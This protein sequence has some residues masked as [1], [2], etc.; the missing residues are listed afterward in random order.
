MIKRTIF[1]SLLLLVSF[2]T[3]AQT[4]Q[5]IRFEVP[6]R[7]GTSPFNYVACGEDGVCLFY[8]TIEETGKDSISWSFYLL[9]RNLQQVWQ[10]K[11]PLR[12]DVSFLKSIYRNNCIY[13]IFHDTKRNEIGNISVLF[14]IPS[15]QIITEHRS[16]IPYKADII[17][18]EV[19]NDLV[20][21]G[22]NENK[23]KPGLIAFSLIDGQ[24]RNY[25]ISTEDDALLLDVAVDSIYKDVYATYK[26]QKTSTRNTLYVNKYDLSSALR[27]TTS[28]E[29]EIEKRIINSA[30]YVPMSGSRGL[31]TGCYGYSNRGRRTYD[32]YNDYYNYYYYN[33]L[34]NRPYTYDANKDNT[35]V[36]DGY[37]TAAVGDSIQP[38]L[39]YYSF[40]DFV[41]ALKITSDMDVLRLRKRSEKREKN[42]LTGEDNTVDDNG[43]SLNY[44]LLMHPVI[45][46]DGKFLLLGE[47]YYPEYHTMT[48]MVY[49][50]YGRAFPST[51]SVFDGFRYSNA[52]L[53]AFD[54]TGVKVWDNGMEM[55]DIL[56]TFLNQKM[57][58]VF[59]GREM[60]LFY[61]A[62]G[63]LA[64]KTI[65][66]SETLDN[67]E[68]ISIA[69][70]RQTD[71][72]TSEYLG[73]ME[74]WYDNYFLA[75]GY[76]TIRNNYLNENKR[77]VFYLNKMAFE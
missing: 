67:T 31:V 56:T 60:T 12:E 33:S 15:K 3:Q 20:F 18:F 6:T 37:F 11:I 28:F 55:R 27:S 44:R 21:I 24:K 52:F 30:E 10:K 40:V 43:N 69:P 51:Y 54:S 64:V 47:T 45:A 76:Q 74:H 70:K 68:Y 59:N 1:L 77:N 48:Q 75:S 23:G 14:I 17:D 73:T 34:Y 38:T 66:D 8:P 71:Q 35:P 50:Y 2:F 19:L 63:K 26:V 62:N 29:G 42:G 41:N 5:P 36:S 4:Q 49:D 57:N 22:Y 9:D 25:E 53:A 39:R 61:N 72:V 16:D 13:L 32:Y 58:Y 65:K 46:A 7:S